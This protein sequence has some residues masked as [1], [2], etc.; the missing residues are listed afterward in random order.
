M[1]GCASQ[2]LQSHVAAEC[3]FLLLIGPIGAALIVLGRLCDV[4]PCLLIV[5]LRQLTGTP[6]VVVPPSNRRSMVS[7]CC[8]SRSS[9]PLSRSAPSASRRNEN[10]EAQV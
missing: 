9:G 8:S 5:I 7:A 1:D 3:P 2:D 10:C 4:L 6:I